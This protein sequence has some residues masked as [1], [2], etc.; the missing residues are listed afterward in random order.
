M[1]RES[2]YVVLK[3]A[4]IE[5]YLSPSEQRILEVLRDQIIFGRS[6]D[7]RRPLWCV[8]VEDDW[9]EYEPTWQAIAAR[10]DAETPN[11]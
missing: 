6:E 4:D 3:R 11:V 9:P 10:V 2:R 1:Q 8:V 5:K 7:S